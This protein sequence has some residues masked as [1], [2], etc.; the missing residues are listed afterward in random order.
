MKTEEQKKHV[1]FELLRGEYLSLMASTEYHLTLLLIEYLGITSHRDEFQDWF[2][3]L[4]TSFSCKVD[5]FQSFIKEDTQLEQFRALFNSLRS[6]WDFRN[7][8][9]HSFP[10]H[11]G[12]RTSKGKEVPA[13]RISLKALKSRLGE[14]RK[15]EDQITYMLVCFEQG[16]PEPFSSDDFADAPI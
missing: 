3:N 4:Q 8:L 10:T 13:S 9:A 5:L 16:T 2:V 7:I 1:E 15:V 14:L 6:L 12:T 11:F